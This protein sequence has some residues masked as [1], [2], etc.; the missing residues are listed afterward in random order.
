MAGVR[1]SNVAAVY[2]RRRIS[3]WHHL[4]GGEGRHGVQPAAGGDARHRQEPRGLRRLPCR[5]ALDCIAGV[6]V[7]A[8]RCRPLLPRVR[9]ALARR[10]QA[11]AGAASLDGEPASVL[12]LSNIVNCGTILAQDSSANCS[13][14]STLNRI[15]DLLLDYDTFSVTSYLPKRPEFLFPSNGSV[16]VLVPAL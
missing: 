2:V 1:G 9:V 11:G 6:G 7:A 13:C 8:H 4:A 12:H 16:T 15:Y 14:S 3:L 10:H 5:G